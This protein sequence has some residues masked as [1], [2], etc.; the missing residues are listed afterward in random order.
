V[1]SPGKNHVCTLLGWERCLMLL[2]LWTSRMLCL[3]V[4]MVGFVTFFTQK[5]CQKSCFSMTLPG[6]TQLCLPLYS[7]GLA[8]SELHQFH[9]SNDSVWGHQ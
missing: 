9:L 6:N 8:A 4:R 7:P 2:L 5:K 3:G 1:C